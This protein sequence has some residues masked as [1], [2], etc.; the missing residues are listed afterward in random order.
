MRESD[1]RR[2][3]LPNL[4]LSSLLIKHSSHNLYAV[5]IKAVNFIILVYARGNPGFREESPRV[6]MIS[7][8]LT[9]ANP[10]YL[11]FLPQAF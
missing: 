9:G 8:P 11:G 4:I 7:H 2:M 5:F 1:V 6:A 3:Y 10:L